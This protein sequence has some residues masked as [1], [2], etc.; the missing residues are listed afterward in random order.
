VPRRT[1]D[2]RGFSTP[3][4]V[5]LAGVADSTLN[6]WIKEDLCGPSLVGS[7]GQRYTRFWSVKDLVVVRAIKALREAGC[8]L[9]KVREAR[10]LLVAT[11][12]DLDSSVLFWNGHD[13]LRLDTEGNIISLLESHGQQAFAAS[14]VHFLTLPVSVWVRDADESA[15]SISVASI[16]ERRARRRV[17]RPR[18]AV[19]ELGA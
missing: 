11:D 6:Y 15:R 9:A 1:P 18:T 13:V 10:R 14:V 2:A 8:S 3:E 12:A 4:I 5:R 7:S 17:D 19:A 16:E